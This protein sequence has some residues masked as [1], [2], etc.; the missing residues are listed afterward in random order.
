MSSGGALGQNAKPTVPNVTV[1]AP[2]APV[3]PPYMRDPSKAYARN[4]YFGRARVEENKFAE[5][6]CSVTRIA[7]G[8]T[9]KCLLGYRL[10]L[11]EAALAGG[12]NSADSA[13]VQTQDIA[14]V[15]GP[16]Q[17]R[18]QDPVGNL[19][20]ANDQTTYGPAGNR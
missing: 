10:S 8:P 2:A 1:T 16:L 13:T 7:F 11:P 12:P 15:L 19:R 4:P 20:N 14:Y 3:E 17:T 6:S 18:V 9:G 5:V